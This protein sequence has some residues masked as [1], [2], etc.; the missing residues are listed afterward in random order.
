MPLL[1]R[2]TF[3][4]HYNIHAVYYPELY[5]LP[6][7]TI[8]V[9]LQWPRMYKD[10]EVESDPWWGFK[11]DCNF[12]ERA[13]YLPPDLE[14]QCDEWEKLYDKSKRVG[15]SKPE[16]TDK[17]EQAQERNDQEQRS[18]RINNET[19]AKG[20]RAPVA[21]GHRAARITERRTKQVKGIHNSMETNQLCLPCGETDS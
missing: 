2:C 3:C 20:K 19:S 17:I 10:N 12:Y 1:K 4:E 9:K 11:K 21:T 13:G 18:K 5:N 16:H 7:S 15:A 6:L 14:E 8:C